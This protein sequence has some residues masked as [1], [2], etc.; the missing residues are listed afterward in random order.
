MIAAVRS[1][2]SVNEAVLYVAFEVAKREGKR[3]LS[4][5]FGAPVWI[6]TV[7]A[8]DLKV[9]ARVLTGARERFG[10]PVSA[11]VV[12]C[13]EAGRDGFWLHRA[14]TQVGSTNR[15]GTRRGSR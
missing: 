11:R 15:V 8:G 9:V 3:A 7:A 12:R 6:E 4:C 10:L 14:L 13:Y 1:E 5:G 2:V